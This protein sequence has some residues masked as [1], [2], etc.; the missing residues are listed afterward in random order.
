MSVTEFKGFLHSAHAVH[1]A[2]FCS[3]ASPRIRPV[4]EQSDKERAFLAA[5]RVIAD[6]WSNWLQVRESFPASKGFLHLFTGRPYSENEI[7]RDVVTPTSEAKN[8]EGLTT[9]LF[10]VIHESLKHI[11]SQESDPDMRDSKC[12]KNVHDLSRAMLTKHYLEGYQANP[13]RLLHSGTFTAIMAFRGAVNGT[14]TAIQTCAASLSE[15]EKERLFT[16]VEV[17][18]LLKESYLL[19]RTLASTHLDI[20][21]ELQSSH[22]EASLRQMPLQVCIENGAPKL[23]I[24]S[25]F[26]DAVKRGSENQFFPESTIRTGCPVLYVL[27]G[28][29]TVLKD[30]STYVQD[31]VEEYILPHFK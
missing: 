19:V 6:S 24:E 26:I 5:M 30:L 8:I 4:E 18:K 14:L 1:G 17:G 12:S 28:N 9:P 11:F 13:T 23:L 25:Q 7:Q 16:P 31:R 20:L 29:T 2:K 10:V 3:L 15:E 22:C 21:T 27:L